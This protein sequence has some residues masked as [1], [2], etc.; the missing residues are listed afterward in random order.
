MSRLLDSLRHD[1]S[2][3]RRGIPSWNLFL[4]L[5][6]MNKPFKPLRKPSLKHLTFK[7]VFLL[8]RGHHQEDWLVV[9]S[10]LSPS[11]LS[12][13]QLARD[14]PDCVAPVIIPALAPVLDRSF[15]KDRTLCPVRLLCYY[16]DKIKDLREVK[17]LV[18]VS[19][20]KS[21]TKDIVP[22]TKAL[23]EGVPFSLSL[24]VTQHLHSVLFEGCGLG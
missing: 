4:V 15:K 3:G 5:H 24:E 19:F 18:F 14:G 16:L 2:K 8:V 20:R 22:A 1:K 13:N 6:Q 9:S 10:Y 23:Q 11:F 17:E 12:K 21:L 7:R